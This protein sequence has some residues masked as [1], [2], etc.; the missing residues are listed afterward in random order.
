MVQYGYANYGSPRKLLEHGRA[1]TDGRIEMAGR[2][3][4]TLAV[5]FE[6]L[7]PPG[8]LDLLARFAEA[9][10]KV[11]WSGPPPRVD[12]SGKPV[13]EQW[14][15]LF[16]VKALQFNREGHT[17][18]GWQVQFTG[19]LGKVP[20]Q[21]ILTDFLVDYIYP[22][23]P[24]AGAAIVARVGEKVVGLHRTAA[25][26]GSATFLG[27]RPRDDQAAS[28]GSEVRTWFE[29]LLALGAY[30]PSAAGL[31]ANDNPDVIS[32]TTPYVACRFPNGT[33]SLAAHYRTHVESWPGGFHR[34]AKQDQEA[35]ARN[36]LP[37]PALELRELRIRGHRVSYDGELAMAFRLD[38]G[39][40]LAA[41]AGYKCRKIA[42]GGREFEFANAP[43]AL[44]AW[45]PVLSERRIF[46]GAVMEVWV[47]GEADIRLPLPAGVTAGGLYM[48]GARLGSLGEKVACECAAGT[49]RFKALSAWGQRRLFLVPA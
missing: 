48:Q 4:G 6:P 18:G 30:A 19:P 31:P 17:A 33:I 8:L 23:E 34:D 22:V 32:R 38:G 49:L 21:N 43:V 16:G 7:P 39:G 3:F 25:K 28:L 47:H 44:A 14:Q 27:F 45:A 12:L 11:I 42:I 15:K 26:A 40:S 29:I 2:K 10:G 46:G 36:P 35:L 24:E 5:L 37:S 9:G 1:G 41:F 20:P 13:L